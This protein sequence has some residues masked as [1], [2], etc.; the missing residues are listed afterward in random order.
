MARYFLDTSFLLAFVDKDDEHHERAR[1][2]MEK[3][4]QEE[5]YISDFVF[6]E[7]VNTMFSRFDHKDAREFSKYLKKSEL[8][9]LHTNS[10]IFDNT[11]ELFSSE[12]MSFTDCSI[13]S[14]MEALDIEK[15]CS[16]DQDFQRFSSI[17]LIN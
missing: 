13:K 4:K 14:A 8:R 17:E 9:I 11:V 7:T 15:L 5:I 12:K 2:L 1:E 3:I 6:M 16:F 10:K